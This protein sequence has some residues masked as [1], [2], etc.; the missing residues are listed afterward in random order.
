[1]DLVNT[2]SWPGLPREHDWL[3]ADGNVAHWLGATGLDRHSSRVPL[4]EL[5]AVRSVVDDLLRP[6]ASG[7]SPAHDA[8]ANFNARLRP[9]MAGRHLDPTTV[10]WRFGSEVNRAVAAVL[11]DAAELAAAVPAVTVKTCP[12]CRWLFV[13]QSRNGRR[14]WCD[15]A[16]CGSRAK[17]RTHYHRAKEQSAVGEQST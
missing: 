1:L 16:D 14:R 6:M 2:I 11:L 5:Q 7:L 9:A 15:M 17:S 8:V 4:D 12:G 13:D 10:T 3:Q